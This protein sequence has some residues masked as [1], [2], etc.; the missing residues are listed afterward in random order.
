MTVSA[1]LLVVSASFM[2]ATWNFL[3]KQTNGK[4][5]YL[6]LVATVSGF[7]YL[8]FVAW[9]LY[10]RSAELNG[11]TIVFSAVSAVIHLVYFI[12]LQ[13]GYRKSDLSIVY[14]LARG[15]GPFI[16]SMGAIALFGERPGAMAL[17]GILMIVFGIQFLTGLDFRS[18]NRKVKA[19]L[20]YGLMTG[21]LIATYTLWDKR[22]VAGYAVSPL[23]LTFA[24]TL[25]P[26]FILA[27]P[28]LKQPD[29]V[30]REVREH[31]RHILAVA[32]MS[33]LSFILVL[34]A[35]QS[36]PVYYVAPLREMSILIGVFLGAKLLNEEDARRRTIGSVIILIGITLLTLG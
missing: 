16:S 20:V 22:A 24:S 21:A 31:W 9:Q 29:E 17:A 1:F 3:S 35:L 14:P 2:H 4:T 12:S 6:W 11:P 25:I 10:V 27:P 13:T 5:P 36:T 28:A 7:I 30:R 15:S 8:P 32:V 23:V 26:M 18:G 34:I 19:G 33:P